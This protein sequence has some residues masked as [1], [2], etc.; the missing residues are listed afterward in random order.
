MPADIDMGS[1]VLEWYSGIAPSL[2]GPV[3]EV[4][5]WTGRSVIHLAKELRA[6]R[7]GAF[8]YAIDTY[9]GGADATPEMRDFVKLNGGSLLPLVTERISFA[10]LNGLVVPLAVPSLEAAPTFEDGS[11]AMVFIDGSHRYEDV[12]AD[13][14]SW[15]PKVR[16]GGTLAGH[17]YTNAPGVKRA[18][19]ELV[20]GARLYKSCWSKVIA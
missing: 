16:P 18:V 12:V 1:D 14:R 17:D 5:V 20:P 6:H 3:V 15:R 9:D 8:V 10:D 11:L 7:T 4:G 19:D 13:I 2:R